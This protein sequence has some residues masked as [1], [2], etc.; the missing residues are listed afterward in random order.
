MKITL[1]PVIFQPINIVLENPEDIL[2]M[3]KVFN[4]ILNSTYSYTEEEKER[5]RT[6]L[7]TNPL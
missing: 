2:L 5:V 3:R 1:P 6:C 7:L 4:D